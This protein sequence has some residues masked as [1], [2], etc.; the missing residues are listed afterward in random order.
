MRGKSTRRT[1]IATVMSLTVVG[2]MVAAGP[3]LADTSV[4]DPASAET[5]SAET[6]TTGDETAADRSTGDGAAEDQG[7]TGEATFEPAA[8]D[9]AATDEAAT[10]Q[11]ATEPMASKTTAADETVSEQSATAE[12]AAALAPLTTA[13]KRAITKAKRWAN[14][15]AR[16]AKKNRRHAATHAR[17][18]GKRLPRSIKR[19]VKKPR[20]ATGERLT[21]ADWRAY[22]RAW[23]KQA[24]KNAKYV[25][26]TWRKIKNP[27]GSSVRRW[28]PLLRH[29]GWPKSQLSMALRVIYRESKGNPRL[30][31]SGGYHGLFQISWSFSRGRFNLRNPVTNVRVAK[32][33]FSRRGWQPW[34]STAY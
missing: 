29:E 3:A 23:K 11:T 21:A 16:Q 20:A 8:T 5:P 33:L 31:G 17:Y 34:A 24:K 18:L 12:T 14:K 6:Q 26:V 7:S 22:G 2:L 9:E 27:R 30:I 10:E 1:I 19:S 32:Q 4:E 25:R 15:W 28:L 13:Q